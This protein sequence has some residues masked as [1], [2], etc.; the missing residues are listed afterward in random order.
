MKPKVLIVDDE[1]LICKGIRSTI[2]WEE[3]GAEVIGEAYNG[4]QALKLMKENPVDLVLTDVKM[5]QMNGLEFVRRLHQEGCRAKVIMLSGYE[6]FAYVQSAMRY[7]VKNYLLKPVD[8]E[9]LSA[10]IAELL[11]GIALEASERMA[12]KLEAYYHYIAAEMMEHAESNEVS[13]PDPNILCYMMVSRIVEYYRL[14]ERIAEQDQQIVRADWKVW[15]ARRLLL[16]GVPSVSVFL[17]PNALLTIAFAEGDA[18]KQLFSLIGTGTG[19]MEAHGGCRLEWTALAEPQSFIALKDTVS[20]L[21]RLLESGRIGTISL[22]GGEEVGTSAASAAIDYPK[23]TEKE[24]LDLLFQHKE[25]QMRGAVNRLFERFRNERTNLR[26]ALHVCQEIFMMV[27]RRIRDTAGERESA[28]RLPKLKDTDIEIYN[29]LEA[30]EH[31]FL[32]ALMAALRLLRTAN[33]GKNHWIVDRVTSYIRANYSLDLRSCD[34]AEMI[35]ITPNYFSSIF[36][37]ETGKSF[38]EYVNEVRIDKA[39]ELLA[40]TSEL[41]GTIAQA[42]GYKDYKHFAMLFKKH[43]G[44]IPTEYRDM[45]RGKSV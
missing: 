33:L 39:K 8:A 13:I 19:V 10:L 5:P 26:E 42:V 16:A 3:L 23:E 1:P 14:T 44:V 7:G 6:E 4:V 40:A 37:Q 18:T 38:N 11:R 35:R 27:N 24:L 22:V 15:M 28:S 36:K 9:E 21:I 25:E 34:I 17:R 30:I 31:L 32:D 20:D 2:P 45:H 43:C 29:S 41:V 12:R